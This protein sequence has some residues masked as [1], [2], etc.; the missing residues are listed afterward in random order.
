[1]TNM[2]VETKKVLL[3]LLY[4]IRYHEYSDITRMLCHHAKVFM[5]IL[6]MYTNITYTLG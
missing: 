2:A 4:Y 6:V 5:Y 3:L 1:M